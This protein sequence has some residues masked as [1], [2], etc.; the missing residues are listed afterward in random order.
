MTTLEEDLRGLAASCPISPPPIDALQRRTTRR[1]LRRRI[2]TATIAVV[3]TVV[4]VGVAVAFTHRDQTSLRVVAPPDTEAPGGDAGCHPHATGN[5]PPLPPA[6]TP[7]S[8]AASLI[9]EDRLGVAPTGGEQACGVV[10]LN[11][12]FQGYRLFVE[13]T[14]ASPDSLNPR[15]RATTNPPGSGGRQPRS[16]S[17]TGLP[18]HYEGTRQGDQI[19]VLRLP[20]TSS[21]FGVLAQIGISAPTNAAPAP[22]TALIHQIE[23]LAITLARDGPL[24][25]RND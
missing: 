18:P 8:R 9:I 6:V 21:E 10:T 13:Y 20:P 14:H 17:I 23:Q 11:L 1:R 5:G 4:L 16:T 15:T 3:L 19:S 2:L 22:S 25:P 12:N 24:K 7:N